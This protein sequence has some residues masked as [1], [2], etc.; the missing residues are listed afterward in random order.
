MT[1]Y[2]QMSAEERLNEIN[3]EVLRNADIAPPSYNEVLVMQGQVPETAPQANRSQ[4]TTTPS[5][6]YGANSKLAQDLQYYNNQRDHNAGAS[7]SR[8]ANAHFP[9]DSKH[10]ESFDDLSDA[11]SYDSDWENETVAGIN[12][13]ATTVYGGDDHHGQHPVQQSEKYYPPGQ[14]GPEGNFS[15]SSRGLPAGAGLSR[16]KSSD[17][18]LLEKIRARHGLPVTQK[19]TRD[20]WRAAKA[21]YKAERRDA[22][23]AF[24]AERETMREAWRQEKKAGREERRE[25]RAEKRE[26]FEARRAARREHLCGRRC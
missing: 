2:N 18:S 19:W 1:A 7:S 23:A 9:N 16:E 25:I 6:P 21:A 24:K 5:A 10:V 20:D 15:S 17:S 8:N 26:D 4:A 22:K 14:Y 13:P 12:T 3:G 11:D